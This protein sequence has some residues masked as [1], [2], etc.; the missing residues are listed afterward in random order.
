MRIKELERSWKSGLQVVFLVLSLLFWIQ[1]SFTSL[2]EPHV[3]PS[4][5]IALLRGGVEKSTH[6]RTTQVP[7][8]Q[9]LRPGYFVP[10]TLNNRAQ[11]VFMIDTAASHTVVS[12]RLAKQAGLYPRDDRLPGYKAVI[13]AA[14]RTQ[15]PYLFSDSLQIGGLSL[16]HLDLVVQDLDAGLRIDGLLGLDVLQHFHLTL[17]TNTLTLQVR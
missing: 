8:Q 6:G 17:S 2:A 9:T 1:G 11:G 4:P 3:K 13:T 12:T 5:A 7:L 10:V 16:K 15:V 14:G